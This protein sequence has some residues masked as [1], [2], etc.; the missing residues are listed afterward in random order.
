[1]IRRWKKAEPEPAADTPSRR[2][3]ALRASLDAPRDQAVLR[4]GPNLMGGWVVHESRRVSEVQVLVNGILLARVTDFHERPDITRQ[5]PDAKL[6]GWTIQLD[7]ADLFANRA[8][9]AVWVLLDPCEPHGDVV[10]R[11]IATAMCTVEADEAFTGGGR[12]LTS[13]R[14]AAGHQRVYG[15][16]DAPGGISHIDITLDGMPAGRARSGLPGHI[17]S[18]TTRPE[19][20][21]AVFE[22]VVE[23]SGSVDRAR[24]GATAHPFVGA[25][26]ELKEVEIQVEHPKPEWPKQE[27]LD[28]ARSRFDARVERTRRGADQLDPGAVRALVVTHDLGLGGGQM[29]LQELLRRLHRRGIE[30]AVVT[31]RGGVFV[32]ELEELGYPVLVTGGTEVGDPDR[33]EAQVQ[34]I[35]TFAAEHSCNVALGNTTLAFAGID[36]A[37]RIGVRT[38]W[39]IHESFQL[40]QF[41]MEAYGTGTVHPYVAEQAEGALR[42]CDRVVFE[43]DATRQIYDPLL[44][45]GASVVVP[46]GVDTAEIEDYCRTHDRAGLRRGL[47]IADSTLVFLCLGTVE[48]RKA[49]IALAQAFIGS[50]VL[51]ERDVALILVGAR[52]GNPYVEALQKLVSASGEQ[53]VRVEPVQPD[54]YQWYHAADVLV[55]ASDVESLPRSILEAMAFERPILSTRVFGVPELIVDGETGFLCRTRDIGALREMLE[56]AGTADPQRLR[57]MGRAAREHVLRRHDPSI[58]EDFFVAELTRLTGAP[59]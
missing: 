48:P 11:R 20:A 35:A 3:Q 5:F 46:Y 22:T 25:P 44:T 15:V 2:H 33:Y 57:A 38:S 52:D 47:G 37:Q 13:P 32:E 23:L 56:R 29:Y 55:C 53:R 39:A 7:L 43:A 4:R 30:A 14:M 17:R 16:A 36:A 49:Q 40:G 31:L 21:V 34:E 51:A 42:L 54:T 58:Y 19:S 1:M 28:R 6:P 18:D 45:P 26:L 27:Q 41:W 24:L 10:R 8:K 50:E 9:V 12:L 59:G